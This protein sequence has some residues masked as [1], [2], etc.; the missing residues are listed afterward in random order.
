MTD[1]PRN[2]LG[3]D[4]ESVEFDDTIQ[5]WLD[6]RGR[7]TDA[8]LEVVRARIATLPDRPAGR[9]R[10]ILAAAASIALLLGVAG[11]VIG[12]VPLIG[13]VGGPMA[14]DP[15]AFAGD[16]RL[17]DCA[18][19]LIDVD[20][21]FEMTQARWFPLY[22]PGWGLGAPELEVDDPALVVIETPREVMAAFAPGSSPTQSKY[23]QVCIA[24][25]PPGASI[26]HLYGPTSFDRIV[27][28]LSAAE[29]ERAARMDPEVLADPANWPVPERL[30][31]CGGLTD[32]VEYV[33]EATPLRDFGRYFPSV[34]DTPV[35]AFDI[36]E[37]ATV[38]IL[39]ARSTLTVQT[40]SVFQNDVGG[41]RRDVCVIFSQ[42]N[43]LGEAVLV[44]DVD[45]RD[46]RVRLEP[47]P[48][49]TPT[50]TP[51]PST[52][53]EPAPAWAADAVTSLQCEIGVSTDGPSGPMDISEDGPTAD[54]AQRSFLSF[55]SNAF[56]IFPKDGFVE[57]ARSD[58]ARLFAHVVDGRIRAAI[59]A[60]TR[61][62]RANGVWWVS[63]V[64]SCDPAEWAPAT[65]AGVPLTIWTGPDGSRVPA[66]TLLERDDC[67][68]ASVLRLGGRL[69]VRDPSGGAVD[70]TQ[71]ESTYD[72]DTPLP[73]TAVRQPFRDGDRSLFLSRDGRAAYVASP[74][75]VERWPHVIQ[76]VILRTD[77]N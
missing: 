43:A 49:P 65:E 45:I 2:P 15:A 25:G 27:P 8:E 72:G 12:R 5:G 10:S 53:P 17:A 19:N 66:A 77:C 52:T 18:R 62:G 22:F 50:P 30:A 14:P 35:A 63:S 54:Q 46:F 74:S 67:Y 28:V 11:L 69:F 75:G 9:R 56:L 33:F 42:P 24:V 21:A 57:Q 13:D 73:S 34:A 36:D 48:D 38:V 64:A 29:I 7:P 31:P 68:G 58:S 1:G 55:V 26:V 47:L 60:V 32:N 44:R 4:P 70:P 37:P 40:V 20:R 76:D 3:R 59:V 23:Y 51:V 39:R 6:Q 61:D 16:P 71:L 41:P